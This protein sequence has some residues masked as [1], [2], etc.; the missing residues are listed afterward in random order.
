M[1]TVIRNRPDA[2]MKVKY[3]ISPE[4]KSRVNTL[5]NDFF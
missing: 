1:K 3:F 5:L 2:E 4:M